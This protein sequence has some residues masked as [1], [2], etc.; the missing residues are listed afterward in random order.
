MTA[1]AQPG[2]V[3][4]GE[5]NASHRDR[6]EAIVR[7]TGSFREEEVEVALEVFDACFGLRGEEPDTDYQFVGAFDAS[8]ALIGYAAFGPTPVTEGAWDLY[9]ICTAKEAQGRGA[10]RA[11]VAAVEQRVVAAKGR[12]LLIETSSRDDYEGTRKFYSAR[13]YSEQ[14]RIRDFYAVDDDR[15]MLTKTLTGG[16]K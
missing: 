4:I 6:L 2:E 1:G 14:A 5:M 8:G 3:R 9:W 13:G 15:V 7:G 10:G 11:L 16:R 12:L